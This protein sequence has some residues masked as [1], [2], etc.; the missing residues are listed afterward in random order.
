MKANS[1]EVPL[2][3]VRIMLAQ[4]QIKLKAGKHQV[5]DLPND[6]QVEYY[7]IPMQHMK[8]YEPYNRS[9]KPYK[10]LKLVNYNQPAISLSFFSRHKYVVQRDPDPVDIQLH[11]RNHRADLLDWSLGHTL[12]AEQ[13]I[14]LR[15]TDELLRLVR[16]NPRAVETCFSNYHHQYHYWY[17]SYRYFEDAELTQTNSLNEHLLKH[18]ERVKGQVHERL[19]VIFIDMDYIS[20]VIPQDNKQ[21]DRML[22]TFPIQ[23]RQGVTTL[24][25]RKI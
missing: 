2:D 22:A 7:F 4:Q 23:I 6:P 20:Q 15:Q 10:N 18:T 25:I 13:E 9:G 3:A 24:Y 16:D 11:L 19:N 8:L 1:N 17:C 5:K 12:T 14:D 21:V